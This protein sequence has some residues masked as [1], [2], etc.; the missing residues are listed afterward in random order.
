MREGVTSDRC[1]GILL[2]AAGRCSGE[3]RCMEVMFLI[4]Q[5]KNGKRRGGEGEAGKKI[6]IL[7][8]SA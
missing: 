7:R 3:I 4:M 1:V 5:R 8:I 2:N 6:K